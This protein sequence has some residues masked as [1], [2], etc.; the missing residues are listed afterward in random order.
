MKTFKE[1]IDIKKSTGIP[2]FKDVLESKTQACL[3]EETVSEL[4]HI[5]EKMCNEMKMV[6]EDESSRTC[7]MYT[8]EAESKIQEII[9]EIKK[10]CESYLAA[11]H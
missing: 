8:E 5:C 11:L 4:Q 6:H 2:S 1:T 3:S 9:T 7:E 10:Q